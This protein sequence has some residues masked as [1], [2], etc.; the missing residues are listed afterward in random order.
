ATGR[1]AHGSRGTHETQRRRS[2]SKESRM[3]AKTVKSGGFWD[4]DGSDGARTRV[5]RRIKIRSSRAGFE[6]A[7]VRCRAIGLRIGDVM[8]RNTA[9]ILTGVPM[10]LAPEMVVL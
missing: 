8:D 2:R 1:T 6:P 4:F 5:A 7:T 9:R 10:S 3:G